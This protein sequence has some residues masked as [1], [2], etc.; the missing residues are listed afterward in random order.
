LTALLWNLRL[1]GAAMLVLAALYPIYPRRFGWRQ[2]LRRV[3]PLT[4]QVF[5]VHVGFIVLLLVLQGVLLLAF[6]PVVVDGSPAATALLI[7]MLAFWSYRLI[8]QLLI[9][10]PGLWQGN[11]LHTVVHLAFTALWLWISAV[12]TWALAT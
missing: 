10:E 4:R 11:P 1:A 2:Q 8:A 3:E 7:G 5:W 9:Y 12:L 6:A